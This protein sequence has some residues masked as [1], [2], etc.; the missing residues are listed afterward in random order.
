[1]I[2]I[3]LKR[4]DEN[5]IVPTYGSEKAACFDLYAIEDTF[6]EPHT[7]ERIRTGWAMQ[8]VNYRKNAG[9]VGLIFAR[10]GMATKRGLRPANCVGVVDED[11]TGEIIVPL[12]N[13]DPKHRDLIGKG[14]RIAQM[15]YIPYEQAHLIEVD[16]L[17]ETVRSSGGFGS[18]GT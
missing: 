1:M 9:F 3:K 17:K 15:M 4:L 8:P 11:Y 18:T 7:C 2:D 16:E 14:D 6:I 10:S 5:A 13:D 12:F